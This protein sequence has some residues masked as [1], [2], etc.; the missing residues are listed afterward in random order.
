MDVV[1]R[2]VRPGDGEGCARVWLDAGRHLAALDPVHLQVPAE[3]GLADWFEELNATTDPDHLALVG[4]VDDQIAGTVSAGWQPP[5]A[6]AHRQLQRS[7]GHARVS[8][9][10]LAVAEP[11]RRTGVGTALMQAVE[12]W[13]R[14]RGAR[15]ISLDTNI[16]SGLSMPFYERRMGYTPSAMI[17]RKAW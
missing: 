11:Y 10:A 5:V 3:D 6:D 8:V 13:A 7:L 12:A 15:L 2:P 16:H 1:V 4:C 17:F 9:E 14:S